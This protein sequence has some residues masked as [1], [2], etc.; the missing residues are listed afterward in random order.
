MKYRLVPEDELL[1]L[2]RD[3]HKLNCL[4]WDGVDNWSWYLESFDEYIATHLKE[5]KQYKDRPIKELIDITIDESFDFNTLA[6]ID[7]ERY[8]EYI[9]PNNED[10]SGF[11][12]SLSE[13]P[14]CKYDDDGW[15]GFPETSNYQKDSD[16]D[17]W[18]G[19]QGGM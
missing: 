4:D 12:E 10:W 16:P 14:A 5:T 1:D 17:G 15:G 19:L 18:D 8:T 3:S 11:K 2:L 6:E 7:I 13:Q 9:A